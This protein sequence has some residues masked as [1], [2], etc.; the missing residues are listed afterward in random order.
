MAQTK[1]THPSPKPSPPA[2]PPDSLPDPAQRHHRSPLGR[3]PS[4]AA[5]L[6]LSPPQSSPAPSQR[7]GPRR[8]SVEPGGAAPHPR[9]PVDVGPSCPISKETRRSLRVP[10][11]TVVFSGEQTRHNPPRP[12]PPGRLHRASTRPSPS[13][14]TKVGNMSSSYQMCSDGKLER[15]PKKSSFELFD[16][17][18]GQG[19]PFGRHILPFVTAS[20]SLFQLADAANTAPRILT[21]SDFSNYKFP[22]AVT[23]QVYLHCSYTKSISF[24]LMAL[25][26]GCSQ[27]QECFLEM[28]R[29]KVFVQSRKG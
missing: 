1:K 20:H 17:N 12:R 9:H 5:H 7:C 4:C 27:V 23:R 26:E 22:L 18:L 13:V 11:P 25:Y 21:P 19:S 3:H 24:C 6:S 8:H 15:F 16:R 28:D 14:H 29:I 10:T 2:R